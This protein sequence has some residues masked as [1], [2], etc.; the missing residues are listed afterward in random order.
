VSITS[1][2]WLPA[3]ASMAL[4][5]NFLR[6][7]WTRDPEG[8][9]DKTLI[10]IRKI[11]RLH[12]DSEI[13]LYPY[14]P[15]P[16]VDRATLRTEPGVARL[17]VLRAY[18]PSCPALPATP[19]EWTEPR[20]VSWVSHQDAP[21]VTPRVRKRVMDFA[22]R[23]AWG[24]LTVE[25]HRALLPYPGTSLDAVHLFAQGCEQHLETYGHL[26]LLFSEDTR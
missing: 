5:R 21:W 6:H 26:V 15:T 8:E 24:F 11:N 14:S 13:I 17:P 19:E 23:L 16:Q 9:I 22:H 18:G 1:S 7:G 4:S 20:W 2:R 10:F 12:P 3:V 25:D